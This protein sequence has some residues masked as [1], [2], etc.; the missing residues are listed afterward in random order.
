[1]AILGA[2]LLFLILRLLSPLLFQEVE[3]ANPAS[4]SVEPLPPGWEWSPPKKQYYENASHNR[5]AV[6][7][8]KAGTPLMDL[9]FEDWRNMGLSSAQASLALRWQQ[10]GWLNRPD[11]LDRLS[12][13]TGSLALELKQR[14]Q[15]PQPI[16][17]RNQETRPREAFP[18]LDLALADS[19][20]LLQVPGLGP[21]TVSR[22]LRHL[23]FWGGWAD[24]DE[25]NSLPG[26][27]SA[28][29]S[30]IQERLGPLPKLKPRSFVYI[31][32]PELEQLWFLSARQQKAL[33][34][35][36]NKTGVSTL[37]IEKCREFGLDED[38][39]NWLN[40]YLK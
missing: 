12:V 14:L 7:L 35:W 16:A 33:L 9:T 38:E 40:L 24:W 26:M 4:L 17:K 27:D 2:L 5:R 25:W 28:R 20:Q 37:Q 36:R 3:P 13:L 31:W 39:I 30:K 1:M 18:K 32:Y 6:L 11:R 23:H 15:F 8:P 34:N 22:I 21:A 10:E 29:L 19:L